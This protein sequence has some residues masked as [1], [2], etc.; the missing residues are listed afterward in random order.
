[1]RILDCKKKFQ[2]GK[3]ISIE[4]KDRVLRAVY[5]LWVFKSTIQNPHPEIEAGL[6]I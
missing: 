3:R 5:F 4:N 2:A 6:L 1:M